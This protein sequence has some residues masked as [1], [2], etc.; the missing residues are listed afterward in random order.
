MVHVGGLA[1]TYW[2]SLARCLMWFVVCGELWLPL[3]SIPLRCMVWDGAGV[4]GRAVCAAG[5][6]A[7]KAWHRANA[8]HI[9][10]AR[11]PV[12]LFPPPW[13]ST[14]A[15]QH[16]HSVL[17]VLARWL[18]I[19]CLR[20][21]WRHS[22]SPVRVWLGTMSALQWNC[23]FRLTRLTWVEQYA[24]ILMKAWLHNGWFE[25]CFQNVPQCHLLTQCN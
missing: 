10:P 2:T 18:I 25:N 8:A 16:Y 17:I 23:W 9:A 6:G 12:G 15:L 7:S 21:T 13:D 20:S 19:L 24:Y 1:P 22:C 11:R 5:G 14:P 3:W 4:R